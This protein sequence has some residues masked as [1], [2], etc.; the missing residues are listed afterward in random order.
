MDIERREFDDDSINSSKELKN[1]KE[2][3]LQS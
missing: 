2:E 1:W 3:S